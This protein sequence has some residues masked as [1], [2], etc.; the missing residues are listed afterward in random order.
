MGLEEAGGIKRSIAQ[1]VPKRKVEIVGATAVCRIDDCA[2]SATVLRREVVGDYPEFANRV[3]RK[4]HHLVG[5]ALV[6]SAISIVLYT[7]ESEI[8]IGTAQ[9]VYVIAGI[10]STAKRSAAQGANRAGRQQG[11]VGVRAPV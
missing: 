3:G 6:G 9:A 11:E 8:V 2:T 7:I 10:A 4:L 1:K 5:E